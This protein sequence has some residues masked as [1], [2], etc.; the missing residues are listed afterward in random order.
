MSKTAFAG[1][2]LGEAFDI[3]LEM[4]RHESCHVVLTLSGAMTV[5]RQGRIVCDMI[6]RGLVQTVI[7]T[8]ALH[9]A[10]ADG[11][12]RPDSLSV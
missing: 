7:A 5:A 9:R 8:G 1:R 12:D 10:R 6:D 11:V 4:A 2:Q 3:L